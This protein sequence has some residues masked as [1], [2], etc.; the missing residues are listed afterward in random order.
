MRKELFMKIAFLLFD[1]MTSLDFIGFYDSV[2]RLK[3]MGFQPNITWDICALQDNI[4]DDRGINYRIETIQPD[5]SMY[6][7]IFLPGGM[8][9]R[10]LKNDSVFIDWLSTARTVPLKISVCTGSL[11]L[12]GAEFLHGR[13]ATTNSFAYDLLE[14]YTEKVQRDRIVKD[15][16]NDTIITG[17]GVATSVDLG[18]YVCE[19]LS[20]RQTATSIAEKMDYPYYTKNNWD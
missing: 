11:L 15:T 1:Q 20:D 19:F 10:T 13:Q 9:T 3:T 16:Q 8:G 12:G 14:N 17:G 7:M 18:L 5:L 6:D 2:T 4:A